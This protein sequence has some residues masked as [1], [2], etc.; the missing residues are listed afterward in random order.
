MTAV[1]NGYPGLENG[2]VLDV[3]NVIWCTGYKPNYDW[4]DLSLRTHMA[5]PFT[6]GGSSTLVQVS[7]SSGSFSSTR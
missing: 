4:I 1:R 7:T 3:S 2:R 5:F 6:I